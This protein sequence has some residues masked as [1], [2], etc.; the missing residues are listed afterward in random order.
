MKIQVDYLLQAEQ[1]YI[2]NNDPGNKEWRSLYVFICDYIP[3]SVV[4]YSELSISFAWDTLSQSKD[5]LAIILRHIEM[6]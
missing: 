6:N 5:I 1:V 2:T 3:A 4:S